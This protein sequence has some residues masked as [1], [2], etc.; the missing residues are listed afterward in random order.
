MFL[1]FE[2]VFDFL[3]LV[4]LYQP[5][6]VLVVHHALNELALR[7]FI[8]TEHRSNVYDNNSSVQCIL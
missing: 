6:D 7:D 8:W 2:L 4:V 5:Q 3:R 1:L